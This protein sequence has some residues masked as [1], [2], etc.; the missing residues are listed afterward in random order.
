MISDDRINGTKIIDTLNNK[1]LLCTKITSRIYV[2]MDAINAT[3]GKYL[4]TNRIALIEFLHL[5]TFISE[6]HSFL[7]MYFNA[8]IMRIIIH[9]YRLYTD[10]IS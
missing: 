2:R 3:Y 6:P 9:R 1:S 5:L 4:T 7:N 8:Y 10:N